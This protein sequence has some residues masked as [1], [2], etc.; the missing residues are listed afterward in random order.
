MR[1]IKASGHKTGEEAYKEAEAAFSDAQRE[2]NKQIEKWLN[3]IADENGVSY[4]KAR[5][6]LR[7]GELDEFRWDVQQYIEKGRE[8]ANTGEWNHELENASARAHIT[9]L[10]AM[11]LQLRNFVE[12]AYGVELA[13]IGKALTKIY[14][15]SYYHTAYEVQKGVGVGWQVGGV[16]RKALDIA[17][18]NPWAP[19]GKNFSDRI[20]ENKTKMVGELHREL[21]RQIATGDSPDRAIKAME[22]Y[23]DSSVKNAKMKAGTLVMTESAAIGNIAQKESFEELGVEEYEIVETLDGLTCEFC[24]DMDSRHYPMEQFEIGV[25]APPFHP[26]CRGCTC[27]YLGE[28]FRASVRAARDPETGKTITVRNMSYKEWK[29]SLVEP[30]ETKVHPDKESKTKPAEPETKVETSTRETIKVPEEDI[31]YKELTEDEY[32]SIKQPITK[33]ERS[34]IYGKSYLSGYVNSSNARKLNEQLRKGEKLSKEYRDIEIALNGVIQK[35]VLPDNLIVTR[36][37]KTDALEGMFGIPFPKVK[38]D[39]DAEASWD[40]LQAF[41]ESLKAGEKYTEKGFL[42]TSGVF[43]KNVMSKKPVKMIIKA[44]KGTPAYVTTN[45]KESEIIFGEN[46]TLRLEKA[47]ISN[48]KKAGWKVVLECEIE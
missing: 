48:F 31:Q 11:K 36:Y 43:D 34:I 15:N 39:Q 35:N 21:T 2:L 10:D 32:K 13:A 16:N 22:K 38:I 8:N 42:S 37:V 1:Q 12:E 30:E 47:Y 18:R 44:R 14:E 26:R 4:E 20:W 46:T 6:M 40:E 29:A 9:R 24:G 23:V 28:E 45:R 3:R 17:V 25:T 33:A 27:P 7:K 41:I 5:Q 19:D